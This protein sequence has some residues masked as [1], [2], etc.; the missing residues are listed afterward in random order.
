[1]GEEHL[2]QDRRKVEAAIIG[3]AVFLGDPGHENHKIFLLPLVPPDILTS[4][5]NVGVQYV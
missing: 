2:P 4:K 3:T 1:M 5:I